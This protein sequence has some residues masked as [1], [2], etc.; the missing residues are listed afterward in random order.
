VKKEMLKFVLIFFII[1]VSN[2]SA[3]YG[4]ILQKTKITFEV[5][6]GISVGQMCL[7]LQKEYKDLTGQE[8][9]IY[10]NPNASIA[11]CKA[12]KLKDLPMDRVFMFVC[13][14]PRLSYRFTDEYVI[15]EKDDIQQQVTTNRV[16]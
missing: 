15:I 12:M 1:C 13:K 14:Y 11:K 10:L 2:L 8:L 16:R 7:K 9:N 3:H 5:I 4:V 6:D